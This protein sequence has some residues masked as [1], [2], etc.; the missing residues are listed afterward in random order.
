[1]AA[2]METQRVVQLG[3]WAGLMAGSRVACWAVQ[4]ADCLA[5]WMER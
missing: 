2:S 4:R 1:M 3:L 5:A